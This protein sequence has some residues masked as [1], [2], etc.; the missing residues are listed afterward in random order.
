[1]TFVPAVL[2]GAA[3]LAATSTAEAQQTFNGN[4]SV[5][6]VTEQGACDRAYRFPVVIENG[7]V[8][9]GGREGINISGT[10]NAR[11]AIRSSIAADGLR[12]NVAG[13]LSGRFG[14][15]TWTL[16][17]NRSCAGT[18]NAERRNTPAA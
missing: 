10:V 9:Y 11:G 16:A 7:R 13:R 2:V 18:W 15:G 8:R 4:W 6:V 17:G 14:S 1:M 12:A 5:E 3:L